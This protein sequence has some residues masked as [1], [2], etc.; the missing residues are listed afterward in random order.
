MHDVVIYGT[1]NLETFKIL[2]VGGGGDLDLERFKE[3]DKEG[4]EGMV[5]E[6]SGGIR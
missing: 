3:S 6:A 5:G 2:W 4:Q 1:L